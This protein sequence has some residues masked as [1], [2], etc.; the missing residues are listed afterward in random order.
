MVIISGYG[1]LIINNGQCLFWWRGRELV[2]YK[3]FVIAFSQSIAILPLI[4]SRT[5]DKIIILKWNISKF[6]DAEI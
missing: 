3:D 1:G 2:G 5:L 4:K 6:S